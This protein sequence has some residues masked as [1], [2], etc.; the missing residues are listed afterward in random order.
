MSID[1]RTDADCLRCC[2][3]TVLGLRYGDVPDFVAEAPSR[4]ATNMARWANELG[5]PVVRVQ[6]TGDGEIMAS[7]FEGP[8]GL[9]IA[10]GPTERETNHAVV[11]KGTTM[12]HDPHSSRAGLLKITAATVFA[13]TQ[14]RGNTDDK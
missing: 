5:R 10:S 2:I 9:W 3:A 7:I 4:W 11:Y 6:A 12:M 1:M 14:E 8:G 13:T